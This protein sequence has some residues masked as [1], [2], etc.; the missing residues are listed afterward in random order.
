MYEHFLVPV[1]GTSASD[2]NVKAAIDLAEKLNAK[3]TFLHAAP[4]P[5]ATLG[6]T[7]LS[8][9]LAS[10][11]LRAA[12]GDSDAVLSS[13][14]SS[15]AARGVRCASLAVVSAHLAEAVGAAAKLQGCDV[16]VMAP[17]RCPGAQGWSFQFCT[18][19]VLRSAP[20]ALLV[21]GV[22][23]REV[24]TV[25]E[26]TVAALLSSHRA[27]AIGMLGALAVLDAAGNG[28]PSVDFEAIRLCV[29]HV[30]QYLLCA[31]G[32][33]HLYGVLRK[34]K[35]ELIE[36]LSCLE[37]RH[38]REH[39]L[40]LKLME[41]AE[42]VSLGNVAALGQLQSLASGVR[43]GMRHADEVERIL[44]AARRYLLDSD[45][46]EI[47]GAIGP[48][49]GVGGADLERDV[50]AHAPPPGELRRP[51]Y[52]DGGQFLRDPSRMGD[53]LV[54]I[55]FYEASG[56]YQEETVG[57]L[58]RRVTTSIVRNADMRLHQHGLTS[59]QWGPLVK[60]KARQRP[61]VA[62]LAQDLEMD[63]GGVTR[64]LDRLEKKGLCKRVRSV[65]DRRV[66]HVQLTEAGESAVAEVPAILAVVQ[67]AHLA[68]FSRQEW[69]ALLGYLQRMLV[70]G[71]SMQNADAVTG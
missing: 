13:A 8:T 11:L 29:Q 20:T 69:Q 37:E 18:E 9:A 60:I 42:A 33:L 54:P 3:I 48:D 61:T 26:R 30:P 63:A 24:P 47:A 66:I 49:E 62:D 68:D 71:K 70:N 25:Q 35:P 39:G 5:A 4:D 58:M 10:T 34:R 7:A 52:G 56:Y 36:V 53:N 15:A 50:Q 44:L 27:F 12:F 19:Q 21:T 6:V 40:G 59:T 32:E 31:N 23:S 64:A 16:I 38:C 2:K 17:Q 43:G 1:D 51:L 46:D 57:Y 22:A 67:N 28:Q 65:E 45:W 14:R 55:E 41:I